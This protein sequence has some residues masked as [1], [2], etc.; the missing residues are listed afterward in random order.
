MRCLEPASVEV[1]VEA[2]EIDQR[3][4]DDEELHSPYVSE[5]EAGPGPLGTRRGG[6]APVPAASS[7]APTARA[8]ARPAASR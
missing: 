6:C 5:D 1:E 3:D 4:T 7:A 2:R 8:Y